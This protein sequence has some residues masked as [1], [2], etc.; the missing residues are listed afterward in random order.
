[1][2]KFIGIMLLLYPL[3]SY[4]F[5]RGN[6]L[7]DINQN[8][9]HRAVSIIYSENLLSKNDGSYEVIVRDVG[10][11]TGEQY[12]GSKTVSS[13]TGTLVTNS[14]VLTA[15]H[16][17]KTFRAEFLPGWDYRKP[18]CEGIKVTNR[19]LSERS[20]FEK[21]ELVECEEILFTEIDG[22]P[23]LP[24]YRTKAGLAADFA[25]I[26]LKRPIDGITGPIKFAES[27]TDYDLGSKIDLHHYPLG[28]SL[29][30]DEDA[31]LERLNGERFTINADVFPGSSGAGVFSSKGKFLGVLHHGG[32]ALLKDS[33]NNCFLHDDKDQTFGFGLPVMGHPLMEQLA[34]KVNLNDPQIEQWLRKLFEL[35]FRP[36]PS[37]VW[38]W[39]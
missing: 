26:K 25:L 30:K 35:E 27:I 12:A 14:I 8:T 23:N 20:K 39:D 17:L 33:V 4:P 1:M 24:A 6:S 37:V 31:Y 38:D 9:N 19:F 10:L 16:C 15:R 13:C 21:D 34:R 18:T 32:D 29:K 28:L 11:C 22:V 2:H 3:M 36:D 5:Y 7:I